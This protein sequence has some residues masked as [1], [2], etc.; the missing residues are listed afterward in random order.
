MAATAWRTWGSVMAGTFFFHVSSLDSQ[1][2]GG[3]QAEGLV[4]L[5]ADPVSDFVVGQ[6]GFALRALE[7]LL[8]AMLGF[9][10]AAERL[11]RCLRIGVAEVV[12]GLHDPLVAVFITDHHEHFL[13][14]LRRA[15]LTGL[16]VPA[17]GLDHD[18]SLLSIAYI[19]ARPRGC[20]P[21]IRPRVDTL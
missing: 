21:L 20:G 17:D 11:E 12:I 3:D 7:A 16:D 9:R 6:T 1:E 4:V 18:R 14:R 19:D 8:D 5:P 13:G 2:P 15:I 10:S